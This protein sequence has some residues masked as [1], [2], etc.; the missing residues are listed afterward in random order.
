MPVYVVSESEVPLMPTEKYGMVRKMLKSGDAVI[1]K[2]DPFT[3]K[4]TYE[5]TTYVQPIE[6]CEDTG[7][8]HVGISLKSQFREYESQQYDLLKDEKERHDNCGKYRK[9]RRTRLRYRKPRFQNR[10]IPEG[11]IAPSLKNKADRQVELLSKFAAVAPITSVILEV[12]Q[13]DTQLIKALQT[14][15][16][17]PEGV[18]YQRGGQYTTS[19]L[20]QAVFQRDGYI[21][22]CCGKS[23]LGPGGVGHVHHMLYWKGRHGNSLD[24][25]MTCCDKCHTPPNH[26]PDGKLW[27]L[28]ISFKPLMGAAFMDTVKW[29]IYNRT[30]TKFPYL[31]VHL[32]YGAMTNIKRGLLGISKSHVNDAYSM[33]DLHPS[34]RA[35]TLYFQKKRRNNR[36]LSRFYD[37]KY[38]DRR[39]GKVHP[40]A[41]LFNGRTN[42]DHTRDTENL[43]Q[44]RMQ[45]VSKG[46]R[47]LRKTRNSIQPFDVVL[48]KG[49]RQT[50]R[51]CEHYGQYIKFVSG[52]RAPSKDV[53]IV[54]HAAGWIRTNEAGKPC[55]TQ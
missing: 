47:N 17:L 23:I 8:E 42:R 25:L 37:A 41:E 34:K 49:K 30:K 52:E 32:T 18:D 12:G 6:Y 28:D 16:P 13:F 45:K 38:I 35:E 31:D 15:K 50:V 36:I 21:C 4:L 40:G 19:S 9:T 44:Y 54:R 46:R 27:G 11:W 39:D 20:R 43:H 29:Y 1:Y 24:E 48:Y 10:K 55:E 2:R 53:Q 51:G 5:T 33:G 22:Q 14:G 26:Q 3:I 7:Y